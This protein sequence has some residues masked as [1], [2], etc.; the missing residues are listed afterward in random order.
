MMC[1]NCGKQLEDGVKFCS[2]CGT[3]SERTTRQLLRQA[4]ELRN[5]QV[6][7]ETKLPQK[8]SP[9]AWLIVVL[10]AIAVITNPNEEKHRQAVISNL[11]RNYD[12]SGMGLLGLS[13]I[14][15][16]DVQ[17]D[18][19]VFLSFTRLGESVYNVGVGAFGNVWIYG[20]IRLDEQRKR[21]LF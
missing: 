13:L 19:Y 20:D 5:H 6:Q 7:L 12:I 1:Q 14:T 3:A 17:V 2:S 16:F 10:L 21:R 8:T 4:A 11:S 15:Q 18:N 9:L